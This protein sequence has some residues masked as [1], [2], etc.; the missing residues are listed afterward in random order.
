M[1]EWLFGFRGAIG[2]GRFLAGVSLLFF[3]SLA[4]VVAV[5]VGGAL[6]HWRPASWSGLLALIL[7]LLG[8]W[9]ILALSV[10]RLRDLGAPP[11]LVLG[12]LVVLGVVERLASPLALPDFWGGAVHWPIMAL[13]TVLLGLV[14]ITWPGLTPDGDPR[15]DDLTAF[16][17]VGVASLMLAGIGLGLVV[18]PLQGAS[19]PAYGPGRPSDDCASQGLI[20]RLYSS[21]LVVRAN[22]KLDARE[23][24]KA[25]ERLDQAIALRPHFVYAF[26]S[27]GLAYEQLKDQARALEAYDQALA[28]Q[29]G[30]VNGLTNRAVLLDKLGHRDRA[31]TD[32]RAI[33]REDPGNAMARQGVAY[34]TGGRS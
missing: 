23:P 16:L 2:R 10:R 18:D 26:N 15:G 34:M 14:L 5:G 31:L 32:L 13:A 3:A 11:A 4:L 21:R 28:L 24:A 12:G 33:L 20:G 6:A 17:P 27:R 8:A 25:L 29:P 7:F 9:S 1:L 19:C 30:Y 22:S